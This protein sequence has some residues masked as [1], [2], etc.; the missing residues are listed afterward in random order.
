MTAPLRLSRVLLLLPSADIGGAEVMTAVLARALAQAGVTPEIAVAPELADR[1]A[2]LLG[3]DLAPALSPTPLAWNAAQPVA[4]TLRRQRL[5]VATRLIGDRPDAAIIP[6]PWPSHGLGFLGPLR[7]AG[8][9]TLALAHL[10]PR[11]PD[12]A[13]AEAVAL[14]PPP[15]WPGL[16][17]AA[18]AAPTARRTEAWLG[19]PQGRVAVVPNGVR[20]P[21]EAPGARVAARL[22]RR[23]ALGLPAAAPL[24]LVVGRLEPKKRTSLL[25][26][27]ARALH[28]RCSATLIVLGDGPERG[29]LEADAAS[30]GAAPPLRVLGHVGDVGD[31]LLAADALLLPSQLEGCPLVFL[32]AAARRCPVIA[33]EAALEAFGAAAWDIAALAPDGMASALVDQ[34]EALLASPARRALIAEAALRQATAWDEACMLGAL[35][36]LLRGVVAASHIARSLSA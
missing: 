11:D 3:P 6:L 12:P 7:D 34:A 21:R 31:W 15:D 24:I 9:P 19:L 28:R 35:L 23:S 4:Q 30:A 13:L 22:A 26:G 20:I 36:G 16:A 1:L 25:P 14:A 27:I 2:G 17:W 33:T 10:A 32:E 5:V 18:V 29:L 8:V